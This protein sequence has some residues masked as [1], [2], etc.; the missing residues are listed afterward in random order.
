MLQSFVLIKAA[1]KHGLGSVSFYDIKETLIAQINNLEIYV[2]ILHTT[3][4]YMN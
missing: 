1:G 4:R 2:H 3:L